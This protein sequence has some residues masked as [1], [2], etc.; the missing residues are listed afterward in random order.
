[1]SSQLQITGNGV[2]MHT[3]K[4]WEAFSYIT[5]DLNKSLV[6]HFV[7]TSKSRQTV[8]RHRRYLPRYEKEEALEIFVLMEW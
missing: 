1:M 6:L 7:T 5:K 2:L 4:H 3:C 8:K